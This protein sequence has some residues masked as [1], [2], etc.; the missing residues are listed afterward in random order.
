MVT[1]LLD[2]KAI[3]KRYGATIALEDVSFTLQPGEVCG[4][5]GENGA[6]KSTL[7][8]SLSG[9]VTPDS[10]EILVN[11]TA[12]RPHTI[13]DA[14]SRGVST[15]FQEL[16]LV[17]TL[18]V[19]V[20]MFLPRP[21]QNRFGMVSSRALE[22][23]TGK[24]LQE[25]GVSDIRPSALVGDLPLGMRQ[26]IEIVRAL[27]RQPSVLLL[28]EPT[29]ALSDREWLFRL[30]ECVQQSGASVLYIS[31]K[32]DE[33]RRL[34]RRCVIL[35]NGRKVLDSQVSAMSDEAIFSSMAG[36]SV[37]ETFTTT[38]SAVRAGASPV[39]EVKHLVGPG[40]ADISFALAP[41]EILGVAGLE[42]HGQSHLFKAL[43]G[44]SPLQRGEI[45][46]NGV[47][48][49]I[50]SPRVAR[51]LGIVLVPEER[52][53]EGIFNDLSTTANISLPVINAASR[54]ELI[55]AEAERRLVEAVIPSVNLAERYLPLSISALSGGNQ[56][57]AILARA[58]IS[59]AKCLLLF[60]P[61]RGVDV[62]AKQNIYSM[63]RAFVQDGGAVLFYST[64]LDELVHLCDRCVVLYR[65]TIAGELTREELTQDRLLSI[66]SGQRPST[67]SAAISDALGAPVR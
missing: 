28:D 36:R 12:F 45:V 11:G 15:A 26:R 56:Q 38:P 2:V 53:S 21:K 64:E 49:R 61:T 35:R 29:A 44:L 3:S 24:I 25:Y 47:E 58:L 4:L 59:G 16:S 65:N 41:G 9:V 57:K 10:G 37:V 46:V 31:H 17:P 39:L 48:T 52:K 40:V 8:K 67:A 63:M 50:P 23:Q 43:V 33:I 42:G 27:R 30:V 62:G 60:D 51:K 66:A 32:L 18:S 55:S 6:G 34:C 54:F 19:A 5:L 22:E 14:N 7:V 13:I 20:N 1:P